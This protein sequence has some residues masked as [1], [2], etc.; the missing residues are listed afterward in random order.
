MFWINMGHTGSEYYICATFSPIDAGKN[1]RTIEWLGR[2]LWEPCCQ[3]PAPAGPPRAG[4]PGPGP[5]GF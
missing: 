4:C 1:G 5:G 2:D 3:T